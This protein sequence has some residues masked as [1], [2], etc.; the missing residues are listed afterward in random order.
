MWRLPASNNHSA[1]RRNAGKKGSD[2]RKTD[3]ER[4]GVNRA[5]DSTQRKEQLFLD[6]KKGIMGMEI[7]M[8]ETN[9]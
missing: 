2:G 9:Q 7:Q 3:Q 1:D 6:R 5:I 4:E 8:Q